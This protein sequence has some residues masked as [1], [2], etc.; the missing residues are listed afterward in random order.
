MASRNSPISS[1]GSA[2]DDSQQ[3]NKQYGTFGVALHVAWRYLVLYILSDRG[4]RP[5][6]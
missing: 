4:S 2:G 3:C 5:E 1:I 6:I